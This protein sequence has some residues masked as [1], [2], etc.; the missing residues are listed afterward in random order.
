RARIEAARENAYAAL[1][2]VGSVAWQARSRLRAR[3][4]DAWAG[5][6]RGAVLSR[7]IEIQ[8]DMVEAFGKRVELGEAAQPDL[9][10]ARIA[11][12]QTTLLLHDAR[13]LAAEARAGVAAAVGIPVAALGDK[14]LEFT[15]AHR[16]PPT[17]HLRDIALTTRPDVL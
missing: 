1:A 2:R 12:T 17:D 10:R 5:R 4:V 7:E 3:M 9:S 15:P 14:P 6:E 16:P 11:L 8:R 13:R